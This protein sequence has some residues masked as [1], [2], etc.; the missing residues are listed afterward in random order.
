MNIQ[1]KY[2]GIDLIIKNLSIGGNLQS[3]WDALTKWLKDHKFFGEWGY[4]F[5]NRKFLTE[6][7]DPRQMKL[8]NE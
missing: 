4:D 1:D 6:P 8:F 7:E 5:E 3:N 2:Y